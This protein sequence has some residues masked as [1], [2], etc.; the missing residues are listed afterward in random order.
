LTFC[1]ALAQIVLFL[2]FKQN[3]N[4]A[5]MS[6]STHYQLLLFWFLMGVAFNSR[7]PLDKIHFTSIWRIIEWLIILL[8]IF[9]LYSFFTGFLL[10]LI[11]PKQLLIYLIVLS[12]GW[13]WTNYW[14]LAHQPKFTFNTFQTFS[15]TIVDRPDIRQNKILLTF[16]PDNQPGRIQLSLNRYPIY[17]YGDRLSLYGRLTQPEP[18]QNFNYPLYLE[19][20]QIYGQ[21]SYPS[22]IKKLASNQASPILKSLYQFSQTI[23][24][25]IQQKIPE[26]EASFL[27]GILLG[28]KRAIPQNIQTDLKNTGTTH[29]IAISGANITIL[30]RIIIQL[31]PIY[32]RRQQFFL[33]F[34]IA[35]LI[36]IITGASASVLRGASVAIFSSFLKLYS[37]QNRPTPLILCTG[38]ILIL[39]NPLLLVADSGFQLSFA[40][41][42]GLAY[43]GEPITINLE[44]NSFLQKWPLIIK[45]SLSE[46]LAATIG[47]LP[48]SF[49][50]FGQLSLL[51]LLVNPL[52][53]WLLP[54]ITLLGLGICL[55]SFLP[56]IGNLLTNLL[57][58]PLWLALHL[59][60]RIIANFANLDLGVIHWQAGWSFAL[61]VYLLGTIIILTYNYQLKKRK[62]RYA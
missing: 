30:L 26:P 4:S 3:P 52:I 61:I 6:A 45:S 27:N 40:A 10:S 19:R 44:R 41:F 21:I 35:S 55:F 12:I 58:T 34:I 20:F 17:S 51:G 29:I 2:Y 14:R 49:I 25:N 32:R 47:T 57:A 59:V 13:I 36:T 31:L 7:L 42:S 43:L 16:Q 28:N 48:L 56:L 11:K 62:P 23:E 8:I 5:S 46:T 24:N 18:F 53:L 39:G 37:R 54:F 60:L 9:F 38:T 22:R 1:Q 33:V 15:G 50:L